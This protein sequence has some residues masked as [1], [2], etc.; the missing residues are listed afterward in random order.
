MRKVFEEKDVVTQAWYAFEAW[1][2]LHKGK[3]WEEEYS[4][5]MN[6]VWEILKDLDEVRYWET[7]R[8]GAD[9]EKP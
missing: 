9:K 2:G 1:C 8:R 7:F 3:A 5:R 4:M 6:F